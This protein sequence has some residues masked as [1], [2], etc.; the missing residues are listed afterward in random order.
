MPLPLGQSVAPFNTAAA[1]MIGNATLR[2]VYK[3]YA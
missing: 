3:V 1:A 2:A